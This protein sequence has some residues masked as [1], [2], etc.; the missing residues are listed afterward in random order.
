MAFGVPPAAAE[1]DR[2][3]VAGRQT[4]DTGHGL[5]LLAPADDSS[6]VSQVSAPNVSWPIRLQCR[7]GAKASAVRLPHIGGAYGSARAGP[8]TVLVAPRPSEAA[9]HQRAR[10]CSSVNRHSPGRTR[11]RERD[12][13]LWRCRRLTET[14]TPQSPA[15]Y[16]DENL[17]ELLRHPRPR[18]GID[19]AQVMQVFERAGRREIHAFA[20]DRSPVA[21]STTASGAGRCPAAVGRPVA[22]ASSLRRGPSR[23]IVRILRPSWPTARSPADRRAPARR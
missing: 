2:L 15:S 11:R 23:P 12:I 22:A 1:R 6:H 17:A 19:V 21:P 4:Q 13:Q 10:Q 3:E 5:W 16:S 18:T 14:A 20:P 7:I 8:P 9:A